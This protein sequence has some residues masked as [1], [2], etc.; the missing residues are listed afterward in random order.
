MRCS[1]ESVC[2]ER[3]ELNWH[4][5]SD[6]GSE[7]GIVTSLN[8]TMCRLIESMALLTK[9]IGIVTPLILS[10]VV[11]V[12][13]RL[14]SYMEGPTARIVPR[15]LARLYHTTKDHKIISYKGFSVRNRERK[16]VAVQRICV[17]K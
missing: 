15:E 7:V 1:G 8:S 10:I 2:S 5:N 9:L 11:C 6:L 14:I 4:K 13:L 3:L 12:A 16:M 17:V